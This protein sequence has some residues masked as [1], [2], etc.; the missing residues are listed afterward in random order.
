MSLEQ[1]IVVRYYE[2]KHPDKVDVIKFT[3]PLNVKIRSLRTELEA[4]W[5]SVKSGNEDVDICAACDIIIE[6][7]GGDY[8]FPVF[9]HLP[10]ELK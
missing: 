8:T 4:A 3:F 5:N 2:S 10:L 7:Y 6:K 1:Y 9:C